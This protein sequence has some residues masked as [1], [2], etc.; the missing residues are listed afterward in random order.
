MVHAQIEDE[1]GAIATLEADL[2]DTWRVRLE[3]GEYV[4]VPKHRVQQH[5]DGRR[6][7]VG[8]FSDY[9]TAEAAEAMQ[10]EV[11]PLGEEQVHVRKEVTES[12]V[13]IRKSVREEGKTLSVPLV[14]E[15]V[16]VHRVPVDRVVEA[17]TAVRQDG[18][19]TVIPVFEER[20][21]VQ[22]QLVLKEEI[23]ITRRRAE[24]EHVEHVV[25]RRE[26]VEVQRASPSEKS[27][28]TEPI[29]VL[30]AP[31]KGASSE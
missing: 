27:T 30:G 11:L 9:G 15:T 25:L 6:R 13:T 24:R 31:S 14:Q 4:L 3:S 29:S 26:E 20:L 18:E 5:E 1:Q 7:V 12:D 16:E 23:H 8:G 2:Q 22:K 17:P 10:H 28:S 21:V 19:T